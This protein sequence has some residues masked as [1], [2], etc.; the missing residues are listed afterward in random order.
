MNPIIR[1]IVVE[2][3]AELKEVLNDASIRATGAF[4]LID[5]ENEIIAAAKREIAD[6]ERAEAAARNEVSDLTAEIEALE[7]EISVVSYTTA[8]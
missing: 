7:K 1:K 8:L 4:D 3:I 6:L 2:K 5:E